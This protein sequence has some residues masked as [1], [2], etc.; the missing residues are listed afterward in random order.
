MEGREKGL[1]KK[2]CTN[3]N[4]KGEAKGGIGRE[5]VEGKCKVAFV[6]QEPRWEG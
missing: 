4:R 3:L 6:G 5:E 2:G 1:K